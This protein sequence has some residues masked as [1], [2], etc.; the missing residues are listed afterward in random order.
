MNGQAQYSLFARNSEGRTVQVARNAKQNVT[1]KYT[2]R[3]GRARGM[4]T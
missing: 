4:S 2:T 1:K 3:M